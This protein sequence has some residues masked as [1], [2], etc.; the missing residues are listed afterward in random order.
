[1][2]ERLYFPETVLKTGCYVGLIGNQIARVGYVR[3][4]TEMP[5]ATEPSKVIIAPVKKN[6]PF[7][8]VRN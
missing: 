5:V 7:S 2:I 6:N 8:L 4:S 1:M 3:Q